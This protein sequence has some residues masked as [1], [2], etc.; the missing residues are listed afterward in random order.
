MS[1]NHGYH[2]DHG[3]RHL[4]F[5]RSASALTK[6]LKMYPRDKEC[7][8][9]SCNMCLK[10]AQDS[11]ICGVCTKV[12]TYIDTI[13]RELKLP[14]IGIGNQILTRDQVNAKLEDDHLKRMVYINIIE[15]MDKCMLDNFMVNT[16]K[17]TSR[18][19]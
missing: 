16:T 15:G 18:L 2:Q 9:Q 13:V 6:I 8:I 3:R 11:K 4:R 19:Q 17:T 7:Y 12:A 5:S 14:H 1:R 10:R